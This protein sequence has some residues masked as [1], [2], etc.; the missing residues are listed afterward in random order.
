MAIV[1][2]VTYEF[3]NVPLECVEHLA[4]WRPVRPSPFVLRTCQHRFL[5]KTFVNEVCGAVRL[6]LPV[7]VSFCRV[8]CSL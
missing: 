1:D 5:E 7:A 4:A 3:E 8:A 6:P 2:V